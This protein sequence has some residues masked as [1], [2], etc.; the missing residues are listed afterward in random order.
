MHEHDAQRPL[1]QQAVKE[2]EGGPE[3]AVL[4]VSGKGEQGDGGGEGGEQQAVGAPHAGEAGQRERGREH[5]HRPE[6]RP[7]RKQQAGLA[8][9]RMPQEKAVQKAHGALEDHHGH[10]GAGDRAEL[11]EVVARREARA[12]GHAS[13]PAADELE[14]GHAR[15]EQHGPGNE[16]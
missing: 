7:E 5:A 1:R 3:Q 6:H 9:E 12:H 11:C 10:H 4:P 15:G 2:H 16:A 14:Q 13:R 8:E